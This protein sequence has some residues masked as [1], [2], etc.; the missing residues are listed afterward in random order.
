MM[1]SIFRYLKEF[2]KFSE[3]YSDLVLNLHYEEVKKVIIAYKKKKEWSC[4]ILATDLS[5]PIFCGR[6]FH[7]L[8][9][10]SL[11]LPLCISV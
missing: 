3:D 2:Q 4:A 8:S 11:S 10:F 7:S 9:L 5:E 1:V 6:L